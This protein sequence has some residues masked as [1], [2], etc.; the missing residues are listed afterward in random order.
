MEGFSPFSHFS[1]ISYKLCLSIDEN[2]FNFMAFFELQYTIGFFVETYWRL[3]KKKNVPKY[4][5]PLLQ[6]RAAKISDG[7]DEAPNFDLKMEISPDST[8]SYGAPKGPSWFAQA[9]TPE[10]H[11]SQQKEHKTGTPKNNFSYFRNWLRF[12]F[13]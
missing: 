10:K 8:A 7:E 4:K 5:D 11:S 2:M 3:N 9:K 1:T 13:G 6:S 12:S